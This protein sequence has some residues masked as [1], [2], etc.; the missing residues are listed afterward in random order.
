MVFQLRDFSSKN[1]KTG[2]FLPS[3]LTP[4]TAKLL[5]AELWHV[6]WLD[7]AMSHALPTPQPVKVIEAVYSAHS[8]AS[9]M[10]WTCAATLVFWQFIVPTRF[11]AWCKA[12]PT[13]S[14]CF[15]CSAKAKTIFSQV[16]KGSNRNLLYHLALTNWTWRV[17][18]TLCNLRLP[19]VKKAFFTIGNFHFLH[20]RRLTVN[21]NWELWLLVT[22]NEIMLSSYSRLLP[23]Q[24]YCLV[25]PVLILDITRPKDGLKQREGVGKALDWTHCWF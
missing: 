12:F 6:P 18:R 23:D 1:V 13:P 17:I 19:K 15:F 11:L 2:S 25:D 3:F 16:Q 8:L 24:E 9:R 14:L 21:K 4:V 5:R 7:W 20:W 22:F 10:M